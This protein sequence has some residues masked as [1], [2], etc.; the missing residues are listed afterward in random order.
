MSKCPFPTSFMAFFVNKQKRSDSYNFW[1]VYSKMIFRTHE[2]FIDYST[3]VHRTCE[4]THISFFFSMDLPAHSFPR[5]LPLIQYRNHFSQ[6]VELLELVISP[7]QGR[8]LHTGQHK[9]WINRIHTPNIHALSE[10]R[11]HDPS[12]RASEESSCLTVPTHVRVWLASPARL[13]SQWAKLVCMW[14]ATSRARPSPAGLARAFSGARLAIG[15]Y[16][17]GWS[18]TGSEPCRLPCLKH[19]WA[20]IFWQNF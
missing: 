5:P 1:L 2:K 3:M 19:S 10:I 17:C 4:I 13:G 18:E 16:V 9:H 14:G 11:T 12:V 8:Y 7:S 6:T 20:L 15:S